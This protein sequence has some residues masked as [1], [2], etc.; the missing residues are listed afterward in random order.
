MGAAGSGPDIRGLLER[1][2]MT[3]LLTAFIA[4]MVMNNRK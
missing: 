3:V 1:N 2:A 4:G